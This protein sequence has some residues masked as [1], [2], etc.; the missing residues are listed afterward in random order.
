LADLALAR[1]RQGEERGAFIRGLYFRLS[2]VFRLQ[3]IIIKN[4]QV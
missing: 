4:I 1:N 3:K 2:A